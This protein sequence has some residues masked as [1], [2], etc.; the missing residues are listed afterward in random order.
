MPRSQRESCFRT[1]AARGGGVALAIAGFGVAGAAAAQPSGDAPSLES[2]TVTATRVEQ[3][4]FD[5][6][7]SV[8]VIDARTIREQRPGVNLSE[9]LGPAAGVVVRNRHNYAQDLQV[10]SRGFG[11][12]A[13]FG[14]RGVR[15]V[16][17]GVPLTMPDG[18]G[19][20]GLFEL[21]AARRIEVL[22]GPFAALYGNSAGGVVTLFS[23][24]PPDAPTAHAGALAGSD[25]TWKL[26]AGAGGRAGAL[27]V[28]FD[29]SRFATD[30]YRAHSR[31]TREL[32][33]VRMSLAP[34][35]QSTLSVSATA[36]DQPDSL[37]PLGL[38]REQ[39]DAD[40]RQPG[41]GAL[42]FGTRKSVDH[43][44]FGLTWERRLSERDLLRLRAY[45]GERR[46]LQF[47]AFAGDAPGSSGGV[48]DLD[49]GF[50]G[51]S[52]QWTRSGRLAGGPARLSVG[53]DHD[54]M[55][56]RRRGF[57]NHAGRP[58]ALRRDERGS[59]R[60]L[61]PWLIGEWWFAPGWQVSG[62]VR[63]S[64]VIFGVRDDF[65]AAG[66]PDDSGSRTYSATSPVLGL[67]HALSDQLNVYAAIGRGFETPT[68]AELAYRPDGLPGLNFALA[69]SRSTSAEVGVKALA[70]DSLRA[71]LAVFRVV[72]R[73]DIVPGANVGGR[74]SFR[75]AARTARQGLELSVDATLAR[76]LAASLAYTWLAA[77]FRDYRDLA[78]TDLAG[79]SL[80]GVPR[81][82]LH[83]QLAWRDPASGFATALEARWSSK[84][85]ADDANAAHAAGWRTLDW[86]AGF[87]WRAGGWRLSP[88]VRVDN[89]L[90]EKYVGSV[91]VNAA[92]A[93]YYE[94]APA[95]TV[96]A[97]VRASASF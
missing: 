31:A 81:H 68:L 75:N 29:A 71:N 84:V 35:P 19:Q 72:T 37:D 26:S 34:D 45:G 32:A 39:L 38:T 46:V 67:L 54:A 51:A 52:V 12:R 92:G 56:E 83:A 87:D 2:V 33:G 95:R 14:T 90:G 25:R 3:R 28:A 10:S 61:D 88:F 64:R 44:Q 41:S 93:R 9:A 89:L 86:R 21:D 94:P 40:R 66:N 97:G 65:V 27:G 47:L 82:A 11:A 58:G 48:V 30:G 1:P 62:G 4:S 7:A 20:T 73:D 96:L 53:V 70:G 43:R 60:S 42:A 74:A 24:P 76:G 17:D 18:Q 50:G 78:G 6:P 80:P 57:V 63:S 91:I 16:Q 8:D 13:S 5:L 49:R 36:L 69:A 85:W 79:R 23:D 55:S 77:E 15:L 59:V 22:R